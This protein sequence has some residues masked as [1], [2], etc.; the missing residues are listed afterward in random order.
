MCVNAQTQW[1]STI[2][3][4]TCPNGQLPFLLGSIHINMQRKKKEGLSRIASIDSSVYC[5]G[6]L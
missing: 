5:D 4:G 6:M 2:K 3:Y 1:H